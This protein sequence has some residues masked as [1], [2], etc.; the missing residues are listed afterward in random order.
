MKFCCTILFFFSVIL[1]LSAQK[2]AVNKNACEPTSNSKAQKVY[3]KV[4]K[5]KDGTEKRRLMEEAVQIEPSYYEVLFELGVRAYRAKTIEKAISYMNDVKSTCADYSPYTYYILGKCYYRE[6]Q[7]K[8]AQQNFE[9]FISYE[10]ISDTTYAEAK[11][12]LEESAALHELF[13]NPVP[14]DP[15][16]IVGVCTPKDEYLGS[17]SPDNRT[18]YYIRKVEADLN[19]MNPSVQKDIMIKELFMYSKRQPNGYDS[20]L[21]MPQPFNMTFNTG[22]STFTADNKEMYFV[23]CDE[24]TVQ[25]CDIYCS[26]WEGDHW[27]KP[28]KLGPEVNSGTWDSQPTVS[29]DGSTLIFSSTREGG[30]GRADLYISKRKK[31]GSW[32]IAENMGPIINTTDSDMSPFLHS[33]SQTLYFSSRGHKGVGQYDIFFSKFIDGQWTKPRNIGYPINTPDDDKDFFVSLDGKTGYYSSNKLGGPGGLDIY[34][35]ELHV[36]ARPEEV[37]FVEGKV[38]QDKNAPSVDEIEIRNLETREV[39]RIKVDTNDGQYVAVLNATSDYLLSLKKEGVAF[40]STLVSKENTTPGEPVVTATLEA[41]PIKKGQAYRLNDINFATN[42]YELKQEA[43]W[44]IDEF[45]EFLQKNRSLKVAIHGHTDN[46]GNAQDNL[47]LSDNRAKSVYDYLVSR[48]IDASRL[49][50][51]GYGSS[52]PIGENTTE[53]GRARNRRTE[54]VIE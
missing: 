50:Y 16:P 3:A 43:K 29:Y 26:K 2:F 53:K 49:S 20:G 24:G 9:K 13:N 25:S 51:K 27:G 33:D 17:L 52:R 18:F 15:R 40:S 47:A 36:N 6:G 1:S 7:F 46:V 14:F 23:M 12:L 37:F 10:D 39:T 44:I 38:N 32:G 21:P 8:E 4:D 28:K 35:F 22:A 54:F 45:A 19:N 34:S 42:S 48:G 31:D 11:E 41:E 30:L 5:A